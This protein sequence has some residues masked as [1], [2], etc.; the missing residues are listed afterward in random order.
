MIGASLDSDASDDQSYL[1]ISVAD[2]D[3]AVVGR[4]FSSAVVATALATTRAYT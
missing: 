3:H 4:D 2:P 1:K